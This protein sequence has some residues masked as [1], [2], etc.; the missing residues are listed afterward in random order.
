MVDWIKKIWYIYTMEYH[1]AI[2]RN[3]IMSFAGTWMKL[4][5]IFFSK[6]T[7]EQKTKHCMFFLVLASLTMKTCGHREGKNT[8]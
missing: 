2:K 7:P 5:A 8:H 4:E 3:A 1:E 6:L